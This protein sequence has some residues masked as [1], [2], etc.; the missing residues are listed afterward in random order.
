MP[1]Q[2]QKHNTFRYTD[3]KFLVLQW[4]CNTKHHQSIGHSLVFCAIEVKMEFQTIS[5]K[6]FYVAVVYDYCLLFASLWWTSK[7]YFVFLNRN[8]FEDSHKFL[9][10]VVK[11]MSITWNGII[12]NADIFGYVKKLKWQITLQNC[13]I[14]VYYCRGVTHFYLI[15]FIPIIHTKFSSVLA[16]HLNITL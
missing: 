4:T 13:K 6:A 11:A 7:R 1:I 2:I 12:S 8:W 9:N 16:K 3:W 15:P 10:F 14:D 5:E